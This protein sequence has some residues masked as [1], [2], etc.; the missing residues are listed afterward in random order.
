MLSRRIVAAW[1]IASI[2]LCPVF[3]TGALSAFAANAAAAPAPPPCCAHDNPKPEPGA[4]NPTPAVP[5]MDDC[6][7]AGVGVLSDPTRLSELFVAAIAPFPEPLF[8]EPRPRMML[9]GDLS[10]YGQPPPPRPHL[11]I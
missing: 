7:C 4:P 6:F 3:C 11:R 9:A 10:P 5:C 8:M 2:V 1:A